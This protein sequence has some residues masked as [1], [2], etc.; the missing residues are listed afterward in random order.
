[1]YDQDLKLI[2]FG[3]RDYDPALGRWTARDPKRFAAGDS[4]L[5]GYAFTDPI[6][7]VDP[8]GLDVEICSADAEL[9]IN[10]LLDKI[11]GMSGEKAKQFRVPHQWLRT[12]AKEMGMG[13]MDPEDPRQEWYMILPV[14]V[15]DHRYQQSKES[16]RCMS[17]PHVNEDCVNREM[18]EGA[19]IGEY[20]RDAGICSTWVDMVLIKCFEW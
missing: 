1:M 18:K 4:N 5:Y 17:V 15:T 19:I 10:S 6:N 16:Y 8:S 12:D 9:P 14:I 7:H 11:P 13:P 3:A 20:L 2:R